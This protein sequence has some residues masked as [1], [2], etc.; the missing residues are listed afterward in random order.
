MAPSTKPFEQMSTT[1]TTAEAPSFSAARRRADKE[2]TTE[3]PA[4]KIKPSDAN[5]KDDKAQ[6]VEP[7]VTDLVN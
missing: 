1:E 7:K 4:K 2:A 5:P 6:A 3:P